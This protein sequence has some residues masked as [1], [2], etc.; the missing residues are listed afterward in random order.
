MPSHKK[1]WSADLI[2]GLGFIDWISTTDLRQLLSLCDAKYIIL[3]FSNKE[4]GLLKKLYD[5][6]SL[7]TFDSGYSPLF[8]H[9]DEL[10]AILKEFNFHVTKTVLNRGMLFGGIVVAKR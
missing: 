6:Y 3:S 7:F 2:V 9:Q 5:F 1:M 4:G 10:A 8:Y